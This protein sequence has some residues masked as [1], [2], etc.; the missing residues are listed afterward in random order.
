MNVVADQRGPQLQATIAA[1]PMKNTNTSLAFTDDGRLTS[2]SSETSGAA[3][4]LVKG[5]VTAGAAVAGFLVAGGPGAAV[6]AGGIRAATESLDLLALRMRPLTDGPEPAEREPQKDPVLAAYEAEHPQEGLLLEL[7]TR[8]LADA[9]RQLLTAL[10]AAVSGEPTR[11]LLAKVRRHQEV[12]RLTREEFARLRRHFDVWRASKVTSRT[13]RFERVLLLD[14]VWGW[15]PELKNGQLDWKG[16]APDLA[17]QLWE[18]VGLLPTA[19]EIAGV[20]P[21]SVAPVGGTPVEETPDPAARKQPTRF[22]GVVVRRP[23]R[24]QV[25]LYRRTADRDWGAELVS[26]EVHDV[27]DGRSTTVEVPFRSSWW[28]KRRS[29]IELSESGTLATFE[30]TTTASAQA[31]GE[32]LGE[33]PASVLAGLEQAGKLRDQVASLQDKDREHELAR[34]QR[35]VAIK[36]EQLELAGLTAT[37]ADF[38]ELK[39]LEQQVTLLEKRRTVAETSATSDEVAGEI[40]TLTQQVALATARRD[41][42]VEDEISELKDVLAQAKVVAELLATIEEL[43][44]N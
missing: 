8:Q 25:T 29:A 20:A 36:Q 15:A 28:S 17:K 3:A 22:E 37:E 18:E 32:T 6:A 9:E 2:A 10:E 38:A 14:D 24:V 13:E 42:R 41:Q 11:E 5:V 12:L 4:S 44:E 21:A 1:G 23:R 31:I 33:L 34:L 16:A 40:A 27:V 43:K 35:Q 39:R 26:S 7:A 30:H 19:S